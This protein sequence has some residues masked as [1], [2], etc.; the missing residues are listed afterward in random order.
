MIRCYLVCWDRVFNNC[1]KI[2]DNFKK[3]DIDYIILNSSSIIENNKRWLNI[4]NIWYYLQ[5]Y[6]ALKDFKKTKQEYM[7]FM[8]GDI[9]HNDFSLII[10]K[11]EEYFKKFPDIGVFAPYFTVEAFP[12]ELSELGKI[13]DNLILSTQTD[14]IFTILNREICLKMLE[15]FDYI[16]KKNKFVNMKSGWGI[17]YVQNILCTELGYIICR[18]SSIIVNHIVESGSSYD[19]IHAEKEFKW[20]LKDFIFYFSQNGFS[21]ESLEKKIYLINSRKNN[22]NINIE[23]FFDKNK[24]IMSLLV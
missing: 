16:Y 5:F 23:D 12:K 11:A 4:D 10:N 24:N 18:D 15:L 3:N 14:S 7:A 8:V 9:K 17:D 19:V 13:D 22:I 20:L 1:K 21:K 6:E 2:E